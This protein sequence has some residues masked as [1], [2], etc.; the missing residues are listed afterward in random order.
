LNTHS[1]RRLAVILHADIAGS[2]ELIQK[3]ESLAHDRMV[4]AFKKLS[5]V[6]DKHDGITREI[7][8][9]ALLGEFARASDAVSAALSF[10]NDNATRQKVHGGDI[11]PMLRIGIAM[12]EVVIADDTMTGEG[13]VMAQ[14]L[15]QLAKTGG[16]VIQS[17][18]YETIPRRLPFHYKNLGEHVLKGFN[19]PVRAYSVTSQT[20]NN[21]HE[22]AESPGKDVSGSS[23]STQT[24]PAK[25]SI[26]VLPFNNMS[27]DPQQEYFS[28]GISEDLI[29]ELSRFKTLF[30]IARNS[31]FRFKGERIDIKALGESL[32]AQYIVEGSVRRTGSRVRI[33]AQLIDTTTGNHI[34]AERYD[35]E[36]E[37]LFAVQDEV[38]KSIVAVLPGRVQE[39]VADR[40][41]RKPTHNMKAYEYMLQGKAYRDQLSAEG[42]ARARECCEKAIELDPRYARAYMYLSD[43]YFVDLWLGL[44]DPASSGLGLQIARQAV[45][46]DGQDVYIQDNLGF[47][48]LSQGMWKEAEAQFDKTLL[49]IVNEAES[50][51]WCGYAYLLLDQRDKAR[52]VVMEAMRLDPLYPST[53]DWILGQ[54]NYFDGQYENVVDLMVGEAQLNSLAHAFLTGAYAHLGQLEQAQSALNGFIGQRKQEFSSRGIEI[55]ED[56]CASLANAYRVIWRNP[57]YFDRLIEGLQLAGLKK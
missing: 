42:N 5:A 2:T 19:E 15:E 52:D 43:S 41:A 38:T 22:S 14:R 1:K 37:D 53:M 6:I 54:I 46:L 31:S 28:D 44:L 3:N 27:D 29:T 36:L 25:P 45:A 24:V 30:V 33:T 50:M 17:A 48:Y 57:D 7:R 16:L 34:W 32:G 55:Q 49:K 26:A 51:A 39:D 13:V 40:A 21:E 35:R 10:Q 20:Q 8:G 9:D 4:D 56:T 47:G 11:Q 12:G 18:V 23:L